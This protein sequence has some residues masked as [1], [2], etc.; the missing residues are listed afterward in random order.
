MTLTKDTTKAVTHPAAS[1]LDMIAPMA[2]PMPMTPAVAISRTTT[3]STLALGGAVGRNPGSRAGVP[4]SSSAECGVPLSKRGSLIPWTCLIRMPRQ[5]TFFPLMI[6]SRIWSKLAPFRPMRKIPWIQGGSLSSAAL[7]APFRD[8]R[9]SCGGGRPVDPRL[10]RVGSAVQ[11]AQDARR[12]A[13]G[14]VY[15]SGSSWSGWV[16]PSAMSAA[17]WERR[18]SWLR[19]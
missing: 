2:V 14:P 7:S 5:G 19:A 18:R 15:W 12:C 4:I 9:E 17:S 1:L 8:R 11:A 6:P 13:G 3:D 16:V 10:L